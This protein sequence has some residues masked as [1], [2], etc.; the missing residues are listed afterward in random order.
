MIEWLPGIMTAFWL[1][2]LTSIS[3]CPLATNVAA[4]S[5]ISRDLRSSRR[6]LLSGLL[7]SLGRIVAYA[8]VGVILVTSLMATPGVSQFLQK[9]MNLLMGPLLILVGMVLTGLISFGVSGS[10]L[11]E[12]LRKRIETLGLLAPFALGALFALS[13]CPTS[14]ALFFG[15]LLPIAIQ[16]E[17]GVI[18]P[19]VFGLATGLP[20]VVIAFFIALG[21]QKLGVWFNRVTGFEKWARMI[22]GIVFICIGV[23]YCLVMIFDVRIFV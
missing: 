16:H 1:G 13:F 12:S 9:Q 4:V 17:S 7:Y 14:A 18:L 2:I 21:A 22:T 5:Y 15:S 6:V 20:V 19:S 3:P 23:Y 8:I 10:G 11:G